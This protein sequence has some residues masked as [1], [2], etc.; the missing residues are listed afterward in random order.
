MS[1]TFGVLF[2]VFLVAFLLFLNMCSENREQRLRQA[3]KNSN[4]ICEP[5]RID[6]KFYCG[7]K[8]VFITNGVE[9]TVSVDKL[10]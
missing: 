8:T 4:I 6:D 3:L 10:N 5:V 1:N 7:V 9:H 2:I